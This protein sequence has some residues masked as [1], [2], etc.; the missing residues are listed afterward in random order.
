MKIISSFGLFLTSEWIW[1][2][3]FARA[4]ILLSMPVMLIT[5]LTVGKA[6]PVPAVLY[7]FFSPIFAIGS[8]TFLV[9]VLLDRLLGI[10]FAL[11][12]QTYVVHPLA[13]TFLLA[14]IYSLFQWLFYYILSL[15]YRVPVNRFA[16]AALIANLITMSVVYKFMPSL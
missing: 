16:F 5:L 6:R 7:A 1:A 2:V 12:Q 3:T 15:F 11:T 13:A 4:Q 8:F 9:H 10:T 14:I